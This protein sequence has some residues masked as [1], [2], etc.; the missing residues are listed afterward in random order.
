MQNPVAGRLVI[1][2]A[3][4]RL[5]DQRSG[6]GMRMEKWAEMEKFQF[7]EIIKS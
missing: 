2:R 5:W 6:W 7:S 4:T 3:E 1:R